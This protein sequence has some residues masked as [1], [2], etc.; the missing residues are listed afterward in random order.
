MPDLPLLTW[1]AVIV[2]NGRREGVYSVL[3]TDED[4]ARAQIERELAPKPHRA[5][6]LANWIEQGRMVRVMRQRAN[7]GAGHLAK[8]LF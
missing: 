4:A 6:L 1:T 3:A 2:T 8:R 5:A 7:K